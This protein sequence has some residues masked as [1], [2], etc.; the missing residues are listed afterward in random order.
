MLPENLK[1]HHAA[2]LKSLHQTNVTEHFAEAKPENKPPPYSDKIFNQAAV[3][4]IIETDQ[5]SS[6]YTSL[7]VIHL[8]IVYS[9]FMP[10]SI[11]HSRIWLQLQHAPLEQ[12]NSHAGDKGRFGS[13]MKL[14]DFTLLFMTLQ[15]ELRLNKKDH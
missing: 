5:V 2:L 14:C 3:Q 11:C 4:Y 12:S 9:L 8:L 6:S 13:L 1:A 7:T 15:V 10:L